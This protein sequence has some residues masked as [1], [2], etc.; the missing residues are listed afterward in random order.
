[1]LNSFLATAA[2]RRT[3]AK[4]RR[5]TSKAHLF[6]TGLQSVFQPPPRFVDKANMVLQFV[7][8]VHERARA[9]EID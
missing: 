8:A 1:M 6:R 3:G 7:K 5:V 2:G 9:H 4:I